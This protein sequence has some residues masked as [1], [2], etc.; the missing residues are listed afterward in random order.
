MRVLSLDRAERSAVAHEIRRYQDYRVR[1][2]DDLHASHVLVGHGE[3][4][5]PDITPQ[6]V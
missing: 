3:T 2:G 6:V 1:I 4:D 5:P